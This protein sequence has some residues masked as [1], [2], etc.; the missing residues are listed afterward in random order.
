MLMSTPVIHS[1]MEIGDLY[2]FQKSNLYI[3]QLFTNFFRG[4][5]MASLIAM[6]LYLPTE[7]KASSPTEPENS[8]LTINVVSLLDVSCYGLSTGAVTVL[9]TGGVPLYSYV[10]SNGMIGPVNLTLSAGVYTVTCT[11]LLGATATLDVAID[12]PDPLDIIE[13]SHINI[14]CNH[15][16]G[17]ITVGQTGGTGLALYVWS[18]GQIGPTA[19]DLTA[20][21][22]VVTG[23]DENGCVAVNSITVET[24]LTLPTVNAEVNAEIN[25]L[26][27]NVTLDGTGS[28]IG[29]NIL[30][31]WTTLDGHI[32]SG[33]NTLNNC[34]VD[35]PGTYTLLVTNLLN[36]C[37]ASESI[38]VTANLELPDVSAEVNAEINC[39]NANVTL[40]GSGS[41]VGP[42]ILYLWTTLDGHILSGA[43]TLNNCVVDEPGTYTLLVTNLL[44]GCEASDNI[45]V[46]AN[47]EL[48]DVS[49]EVNAEIN[50][51]NANVT[52][53]GTGSSIGP[54]ILYLWTTI[55]GHILSGANTLNNCVVD[56]PGTYT[57]LVTNLL[58]GCDADASVVVTANLNI[59]EVEIDVAAQLGCQNSTITLNAIG[60]SQGPGFIYLW[61]TVDGNIVSGGNTL[62]PTVN[63]A[64][65]YTL[66]ITNSINGC[67]ANG[68]VIVVGTPSMSV[69]V[70]TLN[71]ANCF[72]GMDG[73]AT[74]MVSAGTAPYTYLWSNGEP[75]ATVNGLAAGTYTVTITDAAGCEAVVFVVVGE[76]TELEANADITPVSGS[77]AN[78]GEISLNVSGGSP[79]YTYLW[80]NGMTTADVTGLA[81]G[82]YSVTITDMHG[83]TLSINVIVPDFTGC[84]LTVDLTSQNT[85]CGASTGSAS[86]SVSNPSGNVT[87]LWS[88]GMT[89]STISGLSAGT[90]SVTVED[91]NGCEAIGSV[92]VGVAV[93]LT[94]PIAIAQNINIYLD[95]D[96]VVTLTADMVDNGSSDQCGSVTLSINVTSF[97]C[98]DIGPNP[99]ILTVTDQNGNTATANAM[100]TVVDN[101]PPDFDCP[102]NITVSTSGI[103]SYDLPTYS[104]NCGSVVNGV[105]LL[106][107]GYPSGSMF[108]NGITTVTYAMLTPSGIETCSFTVTVTTTVTVVVDVIPPGCIGMN[109]GTATASITGCTGPFTYLWMDSNGTNV[110]TTATIDNL[111]AGVYTVLVANIAGDCSVMQT[112]VM[113]D[114]TPIDIDIVVI[115][116]DCSGSGGSI[117]LTV[118]G[119]TPPYAYA[120]YDE[121]GVLIAT[122]EDLDSIPSGDYTVEVTDAGG[123]VVT[124]GIL[125]V[126]FLNNI[127]EL[128]TV[129]GTVDIYPNPTNSFATLKIELSNE[130]EVSA[131]IYNMQGVLMKSVLDDYF[132]SNSIQMDLTDLPAGSYLLKAMIDGKPV[133]RK[134]VRVVE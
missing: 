90:Y 57:L 83:C 34:V 129:Q 116:N 85:D 32:L 41:S 73:S 101:I 76:P 22:Y 77:G 52:L 95:A 87:Y 15:A 21:V 117:D 75:T 27:A 51:L 78:D 16:A 89:T 121:N 43:N 33:A 36:G 103:V 24:D 39:L 105:P 18:N 124:S 102:A 69:S 35:E 1:L 131:S 58:S 128:Q 37:D 59:P 40:N 9:A 54:N 45:V 94:P 115:S 14:D 47:L 67:S 120:W 30:Y 3:M 42:N 125:T 118:T 106:I 31:L 93:D 70:Q 119:G 104:D 71:D 65:T 107:A 7:V 122:T 97:D 98:G 109:D 49:A 113:P 10:W 61:T 100:V 130:S 6:L 108:P 91:G 99:V 96:G 66:S 20:G 50:C 28:S 114:P 132:K 133:T 92:V 62:T 2:V 55:D 74:V 13:I 80:S 63:A 134:L 86:A 53:D 88:N 23:T 4:L 81:P 111:S 12:E 44:S 84:L 26:N 25:C 8:A 110:G 112:F 19:T 11:D 48:P 38:N 17:S 123:C 46:S 29:P 5:M 68:S 82:T 79:M 56:E 126:D 72:G 60:S 64:G 127:I